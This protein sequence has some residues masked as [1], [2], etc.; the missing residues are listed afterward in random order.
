MALGSPSASA[1]APD[2]LALDSDDESSSGD[3]LDFGQ[4]FEDELF[5]SGPSACQRAIH[6]INELVSG[7]SRSRV[8]LYYYNS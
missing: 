4:D 5:S 8:H 1:A 2:I 7:G 3:F 6:L